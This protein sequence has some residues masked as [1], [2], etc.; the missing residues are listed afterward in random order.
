M[1]SNENAS[2]LGKVLGKLFE[3]DYESENLWYN[4]K[5]S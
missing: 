5:N 1:D 4:K 2:F 3:I